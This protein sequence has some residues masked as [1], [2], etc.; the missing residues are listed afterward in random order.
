MNKWLMNKGLM[1][2]LWMNDEQKTNKQI[3]TKNEQTMNNQTMNKWAMMNEWTNNERQT[4]HSVSGV[5]MGVTWT[6]TIIL[7]CR[8][9]AQWQL[10]RCWSQR[11]PQPWSLPTITLNTCMKWLGELAGG[12]TWVDEMKA[13]EEGNE[14]NPSAHWLIDVSIV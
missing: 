12:M 3:Q 9:W 7:S 5:E 10:W 1:N 4:M 8:G 14:L 11:R 2:E 13:M 6:S